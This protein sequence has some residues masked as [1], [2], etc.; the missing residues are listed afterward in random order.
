MD[1]G[2]VDQPDELIQLA[3]STGLDK[4]TVI[5]EGTDAARLLLAGERNE[6]VTLFW[7]VPRR[8]EAVSVWSGNRRPIAGITEGMRPFASAVVPACVAGGLIAHFASMSGTIAIVGMIAAIFIALG[9]VLK[10]LIGATIKRRVAKLDDDAALAI[11]LDALRAGM[12]RT[13][14][15]IPRACEWLREGLQLPAVANQ[16]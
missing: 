16:L 11:V 10:V 7:P 14:A 15:R 6:L 9:L 8:L 1:S 5:R 12:K 13:P 3:W 4:K 2:K